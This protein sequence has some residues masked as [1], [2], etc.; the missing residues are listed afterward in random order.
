MKKHLVRFLAL[1]V[2]A[3]MLFSF[4]A[5]NSSSHKKSNKKDKDKTTESNTSESESLTN[6]ENTTES[7]KNEETSFDETESEEQEGSKGEGLSRFSKLLQNVLT[8]EEYNN[9]IKYAHNTNPKILQTGEFEPH[10]YAFLEDEGF[11]VEAIKSGNDLCHTFSYVLTDDPTSLYMYT[12]VDCGEYYENFLLRYQ[13]TAQEMQDYNLT[14]TGGGNAK[15]PYYIQSVFMNREIAAT[16]EPEI[17]G[18]S[19][20][21]KHSFEAMTESMQGRY[22]LETKT[23]NIIFLNPDATVNEFEL[24]LYPRNTNPYGLTCTSKIVNLDCYSLPNISSDIYDGPNSYGEFRAMSITNATATLYFTQDKDF[25]QV[26]D[27]N[28]NHYVK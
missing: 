18:T 26:N 2:A 27:I 1:L 16:R 20:M 23:V 3:V 6:N 15:V 22:D 17:V 14:Q 21:T 13:L 9:L 19:K 8:S 5:C 12:R 24:I 25:G 7:G 28:L 11:D 4:V 10:P